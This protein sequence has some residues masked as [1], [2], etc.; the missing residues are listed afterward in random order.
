VSYNLGLVHLSMSQYASAFHHFH[1][2]VS[3]KPDFATSCMYLAVSLAK[4][5]DLKSAFSA[6]EKALSLSPNDHVIYLNY[7]IT[8]FNHDQVDKAKT[9]FSKFEELFKMMNDE[10]IEH[11]EDVIT[12]SN[13][14]RRELKM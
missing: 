4:L 6:Y 12:M 8:L 9:V 11:D 5:N 14:L 2:A 3:M 10:K 1:A 7:S 13:A